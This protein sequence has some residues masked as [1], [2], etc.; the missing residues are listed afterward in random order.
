MLDI[1]L[2]RKVD[3]MENQEAY[4]FVREIFIKGRWEE[5]IMHVTVYNWI[6]SKYR[7]HIKRY[8]KE[9]FMNRLEVIIN[10]YEKGIRFDHYKITL[11]EQQAFIKEL[12]KV[13]EI[14]KFN[15]L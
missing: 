13:N 14:L 7:L 12:E 9:A 11:F 4:N 3:N 10:N 8:T 5:G 6:Y 15:N 1:L 2:Y